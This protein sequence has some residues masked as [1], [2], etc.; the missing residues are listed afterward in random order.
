MLINMPNTS[1]NL[2]T[3]FSEK[4]FLTLQEAKKCKLLKVDVNKNTLTALIVVVD[5]F[6][7]SYSIQLYHFCISQ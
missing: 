6:Y 7:F 4:E 1:L 5:R 2:N 3:Y